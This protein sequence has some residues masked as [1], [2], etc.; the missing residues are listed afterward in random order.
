MGAEHNDCEA[1]NIH[2][3]G[4]LEGVGPEMATSAESAI[5]ITYVST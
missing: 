2:I 1:G 4:P 5:N 3:R